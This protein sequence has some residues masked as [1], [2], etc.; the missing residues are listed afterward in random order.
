MSDAGMNLPPPPAPGGG[1]GGT[2]IPSRG[3]G[4]L[5]G[6]A[7]EQYK[8]NIAKLAPIVAVVVVPLS[9]IGAFLTGVVFKSPLCL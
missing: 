1:G 3:F 6:M 7:F 8:E 5:L 2:P 9:F 4:D